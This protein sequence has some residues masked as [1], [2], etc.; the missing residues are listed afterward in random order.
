[1]RRRRLVAVLAAFILG[2]GFA[3]SEPAEGEWWSCKTCGWNEYEPQCE[4]VGGVGPEGYVYCYAY[5]NGCSLS[6]MCSYI[7]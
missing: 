4:R 2:A 5:S 3:G 7:A 6:Q 1:M